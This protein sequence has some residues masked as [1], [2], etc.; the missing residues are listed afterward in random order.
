MS[1]LCVILEEADLLTYRTIGNS[2]HP[3][4]GDSDPCRIAQAP[5]APVFDPMAI[6]TISRA[7][8]ATQNS[9]TRKFA[10]GAAISKASSIVHILI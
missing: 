2:G 9:N 1:V 3:V 7:A 5:S 6:K 4:S 8:I 10:S